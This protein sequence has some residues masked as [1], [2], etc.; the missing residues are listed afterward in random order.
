MIQ[1]TSPQPTRETQGIDG[2]L[3]RLGGL[4]AMT[5]QIWTWLERM[6]EKVHGHPEK[7]GGGPAVP[8]PA[9]PSPAQSNRQELED[10][11]QDISTNLQLIQESLFRLN[12]F[13]NADLS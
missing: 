2:C 5:L 12:Q 4:R 3:D 8:A 9:Q 6:D 7:P 1:L 11:I 13:I 10:K